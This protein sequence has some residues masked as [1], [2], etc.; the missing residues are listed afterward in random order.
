[1]KK[2]LAILAALMLAMMPALGLAE[3]AGGM[4]ATVRE[5]I[6]QTSPTGKYML[7]GEELTADISMEV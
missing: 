4:R 3:Q 7:E 5:L 1:M 6:R 2:M